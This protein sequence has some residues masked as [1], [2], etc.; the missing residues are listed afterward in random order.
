MLFLAKSGFTFDWSSVLYI[1]IGLVVGLVVGFIVSRK[2]F[3]KELKKN[4]PINE[5]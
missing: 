1:V 4:P 3:E 5:K 2:L